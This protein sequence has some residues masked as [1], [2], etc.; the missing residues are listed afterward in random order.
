MRALAPAALA[1]L[2]ACALAT[3]CNGTAGAG[4]EVDGSVIVSTAPR[5]PI[6][7]LWEVK[8]TTPSYFYKLGDGTRTGSQFALTFDADPPAEALDADG[9]G[10]ATFALLP[11]TATAVP[12]GKVATADLSIQ[13]ISA[14]TAVVFRRADATGPAWSTALP[15]R[16][17][18]VRCLRAQGGAAD[19]F[20][21]MPCGGVSIGAPGAP[22]CNW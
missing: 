2:A 6:V 11:D 9:F 15:A 5:G 17:S 12:D 20:E 10:V 8:S 14:D 21:L 22:R 13:G 16:F 3:A 19:S 1:A 18:C 7:A 4:F